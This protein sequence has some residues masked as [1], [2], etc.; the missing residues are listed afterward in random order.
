MSTRNICVSID[1]KVAVEIE[2]LTNRAVEEVTVELLQGFLSDKRRRQIPMIELGVSW[3]LD[4][5]KMMLSV[6]GENKIPV[7][8]RKIL[9]DFIMKDQNRQ[10]FFPSGVPKLRN[11]K[12]IRVV[13]RKLTQRP[14]GQSFIAHLVI[15]KD[16]N[17]FMLEVYPNKR[18]TYVKLAVYSH[19]CTLPWPRGASPSIPQGMLKFRNERF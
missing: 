17:D 2:K 15:P 7:N 10:G 1:E 12:Q 16:W 13:N 19:L 11:R 5:Y 6:W 4:W 14:D 3:P 8:V 18:S 9:R